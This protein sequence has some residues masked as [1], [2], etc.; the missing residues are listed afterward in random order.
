[1]HEVVLAPPPCHVPGP[2]PERDALRRFED[3]LSRSKIEHDVDRLVLLD[4]QISSR[5]FLVRTTILA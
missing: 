4:R 1:M 5:L 2:D 3:L